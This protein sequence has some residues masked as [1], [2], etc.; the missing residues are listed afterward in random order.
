MVGHFRIRPE[1]PQGNSPAR[2]GGVSVDVSG[3]EG[4]KDHPHT[5]WVIR[6]AVLIQR[7]GFPFGP[8]G[9]AFIRN[10]DPGLTARAITFGAFGPTRIDFSDLNT[11][12]NVNVGLKLR[13]KTLGGIV[14][15]NTPVF[16]RWFTRVARRT[17]RDHR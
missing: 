13:I 10:P 1:G 16:I 11:T 14:V 6:D 9:L 15:F 4:R 8:P 5:S 2:E 3:P 7:V 12:V 17:C